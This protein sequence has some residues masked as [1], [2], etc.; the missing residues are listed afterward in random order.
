VPTG[1]SGGRSMGEKSMRN[2]ETLIEQLR[3]VPAT[4]TFFSC[5]HEERELM[6]KA[7]EQKEARPP[8]P[9]SGDR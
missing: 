4:Q 1:A 6:A 3:K 2:A 8:A 9:P 5:G 7:L